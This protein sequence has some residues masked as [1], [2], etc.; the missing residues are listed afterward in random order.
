MIYDWI[1]LIVLLV[2]VTILAVPLGS[3]IARVLEGERTFLSPILRPVERLIYRLSGIDERKET[4]W[5]KY[6][7]SLLCFNGVGLVVLFLFQLVQKWLPLNPQHLPPVRWDTAFNTA[8]SFVTNTN[9]QSYSGEKTMSYFVQM[10]GLTV[11]NFVSAATG[12]AAAAAFIRGFARRT[13]HEI[14]NFWVDLV[15]S[16]L[17]LLLPLSLILALILVSQGVIQTFRSSVPVRTLE[18]TTQTIAVGP[19]ASQVAIKELGSNG[20]GF[21]NT[22]SAHPFENPNRVTNFFETLVI[23]LIPAAFPFA[24]GRIVRNRRQGTAI[25]LVMMALFLAGLGLALAAELHGNPNLARVGVSG[26]TNL[27]GQEVRFGPIQSVL[28]GQSTTAT[29]NGSVNSMHDSAMPL[30]G[31]VY[32]FNIFIGEVIFGGVGVGLMG[33]IFYA[34][35]TMFLVGLMIGRTPDAFGKKLEPFEMIMT[36]IAVLAPPIVMLTLTAGGLSLRS[37]L[38]SIANPGAH[39]LS[40]IFYAF[41]SAVGN[42]G[43]AFAGLN[44]NTPFYNLTTALGMIAGRLLTI[45]PGLAIAGSLARKRS[46]PADAVAFPST[47]LLFIV[48][49]I[50]VIVVFAALTFF[51]VVALGPVLEHLYL[52]PH[53]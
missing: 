37:G 5:K 24:F 17:Y 15:R 23:L 48:T 36:V 51:P 33:I 25:F 29:S 34:I 31:L 8:V 38:G 30:T 39:G 20:G 12:I 27:E 14:G 41:A 43:S 22:N 3:F 42:N 44:A 9:W 18:G 21:F 19:V 16:T 2:F 50:G 47:S 6:A 26:G 10:L 32:L 1:Q 46:L 28:W 49:L 35:V 52:L 4:G 45:V 53:P 7:F 11:E 40:E 13:T